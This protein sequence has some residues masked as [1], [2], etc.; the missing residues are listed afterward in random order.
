MSEPS[1][2]PTQA[3]KAR[4]AW[5]TV[6]VV[7][8]LL[9]PLLPFVVRRPAM[10]PNRITLAGGALSIGAGCA[11]LLHAYVLG[12]FLFEFHFFL[13]CLDGKVARLRGIGSERGAFLDLAVDFVGT[14]WCLGA[15]GTAVLSSTSAAPLSLLTAGLYMAYTWSTLSR[16]S[17]SDLKAQAPPVPEAQRGFLARHRLNPVPFGVEVET[18]TLFVLPLTSSSVALAV[19]LVVADCFYVVAAARNLRCAFLASAPPR[20]TSTDADDR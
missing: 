2:D 10:T 8:P 19:G 15:L 17:L 3:D 13:D 5:W 16:R 4:D 6:L 18:L 11:F 12:A 9:R 20:R 1:L 14:S 7:D